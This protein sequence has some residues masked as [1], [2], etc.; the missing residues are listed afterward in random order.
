[1]ISMIEKIQY[2]FMMNIQKKLKYKWY[3]S[4]Q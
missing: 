4:G 2:P 1:M 3:I